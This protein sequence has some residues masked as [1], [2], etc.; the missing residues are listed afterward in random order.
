MLV[1]NFMFIVISFSFID[2]PIGS[3]YISML[4]TIEFLQK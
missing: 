4:A 1:L 3:D 2:L